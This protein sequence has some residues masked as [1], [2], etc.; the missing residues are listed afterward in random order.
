MRRKRPYET[1]ARKAVPERVK[2]AILVRQE[3]CCADCGTRLAL[4]RMVFDHRPPLA[5][6]EASDEANDPD[7]IAAICRACDRAKTPGDLRAIARTKRLAEEHQAFL[8]RR[9]HR[10]P[11]RR[12][13]SQ[14]EWDEMTRLLTPR[15]N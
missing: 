1:C 14:K 9:A 12:V 4:G 2:R 5:L 13:A 11:G 6:R 15:G 10:V 3:G 7:R 8:E